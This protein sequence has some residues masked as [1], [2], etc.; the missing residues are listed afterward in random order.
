MSCVYTMLS[1]D[2]ECY[3]NT[4]HCFA[5]RCG[6][7]VLCVVQCGTFWYVARGAV[8]HAPP[9]KKTREQKLNNKQICCQY[10]KINLSHCLFLSLCLKIFLFCAP[11]LVIFVI[12]AHFLNLMSHHKL[13]RGLWDSKTL[14]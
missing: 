4:L 8:T 1:N 2:C 5:V 6:G 14:F 10:C 9:K 11:C 7:A 3:C 13:I 12:S